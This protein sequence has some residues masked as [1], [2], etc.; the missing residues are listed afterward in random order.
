M[1]C[2][3]SSLCGC[4]SIDFGLCVTV[5]IESALIL[6]ACKDAPPSFLVGID[7]G[8]ASPGCTHTETTHLVVKCAHC[9]VRTIHAAFQ[10]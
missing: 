8:N 6:Y 5:R 1:R 10:K 4:I 9:G 7:G 2:V 3:L